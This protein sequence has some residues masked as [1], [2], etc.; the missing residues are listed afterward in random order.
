M[1]VTT[2]EG[3]GRRDLLGDGAGGGFGLGVGLGA[4]ERLGVGS[5][6]MTPLGELDGSARAVLLGE[7]LG[8]G[9]G[10]GGA[11]AAVPSRVV[12]VSAAA[13]RPSS[14][15]RRTSGTRRL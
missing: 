13:A 10:E 14:S 9:D 11:A 12:D 2:A 1:T 4:V 8:E 7:A 6:G 5:G 3:D 15:G